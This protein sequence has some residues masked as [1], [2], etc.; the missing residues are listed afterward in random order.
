MPTRRSILAVLGA[1]ASTP[2]L[3]LTSAPEPRPASVST[4]DAF[5][6]SFPG[7]EGSDIRLADYRGQALLVV[8]TASRCGFTP[9]YAG[10]QDLWTRYRARGLVVIGVPSNDFGQELSSSREIAGFCSRE[11]GVTF[12]MAAA[13]SVR[14][15]GAHPFYRWAQASQ[16][17]APRWNFHKYV[18]GRDGRIAGSFPSE[19]R[20][21]DP[22]MIAA[23]ERALGTR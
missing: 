17:D 9:Q 8:N 4:P 11:F 7:L 14:G 13:Q 21:T 20:P 5:G 6:F 18:V 2:A 12:P 15:A 19:V 22:R 16:G 10:L 3:A 23:I 1:A